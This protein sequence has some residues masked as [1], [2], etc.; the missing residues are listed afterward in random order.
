MNP[1]VADVKVCPLLHYELYGRKEGRMIC[2]DDV[3]SHSIG[4]RFRRLTAQC[5]LQGKGLE[6]GPSYNPICPKRKG[7]D[8]ET[9]DCLDADGLRTRYGNDPNSQSFVWQI[10]DV[11]YIWD[12]ED[13]RDLVG[14]EGFYDFIVASHLIEHTTDFIGFLQ[15]CAALLKEDG[16]LSLAVPNKHNCFDFFR[17]NTSL[18]QVIDKHFGEASRHGYGSLVEQRSYLASLNG[19]TSW[20]GNILKTEKNLCFLDTKAFARQGLEPSSAYIDVHEWV[21]TP[22]SFRILI[23]DLN[24]LGF[25][26]L[27]EVSFYNDKDNTNEF[28]ISLKKAS[29]KQSSEFDQQRRM[30]LQQ[31]RLQDEFDFYNTYFGPVQPENAIEPMLEVA[32]RE[33]T[34]QP[35]IGVKGALVIWVKKHLPKPLWG[36]AGKI[37]HLLR[38]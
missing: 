32:H 36:I 26:D 13:Y 37:K 27:E 29:D 12:G 11:D 19:N 3:V 25:I 33:N 30:M 20:N 6:I 10:E 17:E 31:F 24:E 22:G 18:S 4:E 8:V 7:F 38:W 9:I 1:D 28:C 15:Q 35:V 5:N 23:H 16:V 2:E 34:I 21:F 14:K